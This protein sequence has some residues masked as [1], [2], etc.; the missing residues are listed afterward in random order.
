MVGI[1]RDTCISADT[2]ESSLLA[3]GAVLDAVDSVIKG[4][5]QNAFCAVRP[6]GHHAGVYG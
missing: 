3:C 1:D 6:P 5:A 4:E 2:W